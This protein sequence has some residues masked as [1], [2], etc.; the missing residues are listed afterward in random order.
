[1]KRFVTVI[2]ATGRRT[3]PLLIGALVA[4]AAGLGVLVPNF[5]TH[6]VGTPVMGPAINAG[7]RVVVR[8]GSSVERGSVVV[9]QAWEDALFTVRVIGLAGDV[10]ACCGDNNTLS[11]N[12]K[13]V[14]EPYAH[15]ATDAFGDFTVTV[16]PG[17]IFV[18]GDSRDVSV[19]S[20]SHIEN[21]GGTLPLDQVR[22]PAVAVATPAWRARL[23]TGSSDVP[24]LILGITLSA[25]GM[26][27]LIVAGWPYAR[28][29]AAVV[30]R[31][32]LGAAKGD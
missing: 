16:P 24:L 27:A 2:N 30:R 28:R 3:R 25:G 4:L 13:P 7:E 8:D 26:I 10:V 5:S 17:R 14:S 21:D 19:D 23:L 20:R 15:G 32:R 11:I 9:V 29:L 6:V 22:G 18:L 12:G 1:M 31:L